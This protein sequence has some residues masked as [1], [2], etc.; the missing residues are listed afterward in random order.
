MLDRLGPPPVAGPLTACQRARR[1]PHGV[2][3]AGGWA[4]GTPLEVAVAPMPGE[5]GE[6]WRGRTEAGPA[7]GPRL[8]ITLTDGVW[9][10]DVGGHRATFVLAPDRGL[11]L[12]PGWGLFAPVH[13]IHDAQS[14]VHGDLGALARLA[15]HVH[16]AGGAFTATLPLLP[17]F[18]APTTVAGRPVAYDPSP[19]A[20]VSRAFWD[21][22]LV[23]AHHAAAMP[24]PTR[25]VEPDR[26][27]REAWPGLVAEAA[28]HRAE[29]EAWLAADPEHAAYAAF[30]GGDD[31]AAVRAFAWAQHHADAR[32]NALGRERGL[33][34]DLPLGTHALGFDVRRH[35]QR[36][37]E[38]LGVGAPPDS[39]FRGGQDWGFPPMDL[40]AAAL[41]GFALMRRCLAHHMAPATILRVDHVAWLHRVY[42]IPEGASATDGVYRRHPDWVRESLYGLLTLL[43]HRHQCAVVGE[44][45]GTVPAEVREAMDEAGLARSWVLQLEM[46]LPE[47]RPIHAAVPT[48]ALASLNTHDLPLF[49]A[50]WLAED[51]GL[52]ASLGL[53]DEASAAAAAERRV[54]ERRL[55]LRQLGLPEQASPTAAL[56]AALASM[57]TSRAGAVM[58]SL[59]DLWLERRPQN[60]P[61]TSSIERPNWRGRAARPTEVL[62]DLPRSPSLPGVL[63]P[64]P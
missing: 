56:E 26:V 43:G 18:L 39:L 24:A 22:L 3:L 13:A 25:F 1:T 28:V 41:D 49:A 20:P 5:P 35:P 53:L 44:D 58:V 27:W 55:L 60:V 11:P 29:T 32:M 9:S 30:R 2:S 8:P 51:V 15:D 61:G 45:L 16:A 34:L 6:P 37:I 36:F 38:G 59:E 62:R 10:I 12:P 50:W 23:A 63:S 57:G 40:E 4:P 31:P 64:L 33:L 46:A 47:P 42:C 48:G 52:F 21:E 17:R 19:Y 14:P 54:G 7:G